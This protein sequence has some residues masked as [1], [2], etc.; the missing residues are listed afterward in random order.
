[1][2]NQLAREW[3]LV[4]LR[5]VLSIAFGI[6][7]FIWPGITLLV[8]VLFFGA[9]MLVDG[10]VALIAAIRFRY[11][12]E[13]WPMLLLE[14]IL[15][16]VIGVVSLIQPAITALAWLYTIAAWAIVTGVLEIVF[17][18]RVRRLITGEIWVA[19]MGILSIVLGVALAA[20]PGAGLLAWV[21]LIGAYA[22][23]FGIFLVGF[24]MRLRRLASGVSATGFTQAG[25]VR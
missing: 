19:L 17:A 13:R 14:G 15:G 9:Y 22:I 24:A 3:W 18:V 7:A 20:L 12:R 6:L 2:V 25:G 23:I 8:L 16:I 5:G 1:M 10:V 4:A 21:W 11:E